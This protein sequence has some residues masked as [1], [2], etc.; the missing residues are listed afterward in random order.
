MKTNI[1]DLM[2]CWPGPVPDLED[3]PVAD[4]D[5]LRARTLEKVRA[6]GGRTKRRRVPRAVVL[7]AVLAACVVGAGAATGQLQAV[8]TRDWRHDTLVSSPE[9]AA[10][11]AARRAEE[12]GENMAYGWINP[13]GDPP[14]PLEEMVEKARAK[15]ASWDTGDCIGGT[16]GPLINRWTGPEVTDQTGAVW[17]RTIHGVEQGH[18]PLSALFPRTYT[19]YEYTARTP[20]DLD[21]VLSGLVT[22]DTDWLTETFTAPDWANFYY[23]IYDSR[24]VLRGEVCHLLY[25][26]PE[27]RYVQLSYGYAP[28]ET[29][30][31]SYLMESH[32]DRA[33]TYTSA[34]G[35]E[36]VIRT[37]NG[38]LWA[39]T[40]TPE[41][42]LSLYGGYLTVEEA[43]AILDHI[44]VELAPED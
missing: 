23:R 17:S 36:A 5:A 2:D 6:Q 9:E 4:L 11:D 33:E 39:D 34:T 37:K 10:A 13:N 38:I 42:L 25:T 18:S 28:G 26:L 19:K 21:T 22:P 24:Q 29:F 30:S 40:A 41:F 27:G 3:Q 32:Y 20:A 1:S 7:A 12:T 8:L 16:F 15:S 31:S 14:V 44:S 35:L 43:E